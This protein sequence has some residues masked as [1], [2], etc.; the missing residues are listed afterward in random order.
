MGPAVDGAVLSSSKLVAGVDEVGR[1][2]LAG[3]V[4]AAA[5]ILPPAW[6]LPGLTDSKRLSSR[7]RSELAFL[8]KAQAVSWALGF[9]WPREIDAVNI[10][11]STLRAMARAVASLAVV[12]HWV[13]VDGNQVFPAEVP[14]RAFVG[15]D[16]DVPAISAASIVAKTFRDRLMELAGQRYPGYGL[17]RHKGYGT[18]EHRAALVRLGPCPLHRQSFQGV[19]PVGRQVWMPGISPSL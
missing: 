8:I 6:H 11:R 1:G 15:G 5:V 12:P 9:S 3:P 13:A 16:K 7:R 19:R 14:V 18:A 2:C 10:L 4:V 17:E